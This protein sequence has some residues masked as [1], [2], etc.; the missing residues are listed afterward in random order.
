MCGAKYPPAPASSGMLNGG[1]ID[2]AHM[3][4]DSDCFSNATASTLRWTP[5]WTR[6]VAT[7]PVAPPTEPAVCT[8][9]SGLPVAPSASD[10]YS[11][12]IIT[13]SN[14]SG[15]F[16]TTTASMS[17][18]VLPESA[19]ARS[20]AS[21]QRPAIDTS[22]RRDRWRVWPTPRTAARCF[23]T[24]LPSLGLQHADKV[25][26]QGRTA[27]GVAQ[28]SVRAAGHD[29][30]C[31][32]PDAGQAGREHR[33]AAQ[34]AA[35]GVDPD[36]ATQAQRAAEQD[37]LMGEGCVQF[38]DLDT[39]G[40]C[41]PP[42]GSGRRRRGQVAR[43]QRSRVDPV[44][45]PG[46]PG[47]PRAQL[48]GPVGGGEYHDGGSVAD[49]CAVVSPERIGDV[50]AVQQFLGG[51]LTGALS[52][53]VRDPGGAGARRH[54]SHFLLAPDTGLDAEPGLQRRHGHRVGP[55]RGEQ[56]RVEL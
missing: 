45:E 27:G 25:L 49:R 8:R 4:L 13:P 16:P 10:R 43:S 34:R 7:L 24:V 55:E 51:E 46:D 35:G 5:A 23:I 32:R 11:S 28:G 9:S 52:L 44:L 19:S 6:L 14:R 29:L 36:A 41:R 31:G 56:V 20:T 53:R 47:G 48:A 26:L 30:A 42:G 22:A 33:V 54:L 50:G 21:R 18:R 17:A 37:L 3:A 12:G 15:A 2:S 40:S 39:R 38:G 1:V